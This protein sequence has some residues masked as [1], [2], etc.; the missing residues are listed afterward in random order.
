MSKLLTLIKRKKLCYIHG[1]CKRT[2]QKLLT[3]Q[4]WQAVHSV[5]AR[6]TLVVWYSEQRSNQKK[7]KKK[8]RDMG[9]FS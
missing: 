6:K 8:N 1:K 7:K 5:K 9:I 2:S 3:F 4:N